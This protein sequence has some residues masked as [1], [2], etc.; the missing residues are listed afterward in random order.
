MIGVEWEP[1]VPDGPNH[2]YISGTLS[3]DRSE[4]VQIGFR[5]ARANGLDSVQ[6]FDTPLSL[7]FDPAAAFAFAFAEAHG[8]QDII[9]HIGAVSDANVALQEATLRDSGVAATVRLLNHRTSAMET[10][11]LY[12]E[13]LK[14]GQGE[15]QPGL[16]TVLAWY[17]RHL[18]ICA[19]LLQSAKPGDRVLLLVGAGRFPLLPQCD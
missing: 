10:H 2:R 15:Q 17:Q 18:G 4:I 14:L 1:S 7:P 12:R 5:V 8:H 6:G 13:R 11:G 9:E 16:S 3:P 19:C